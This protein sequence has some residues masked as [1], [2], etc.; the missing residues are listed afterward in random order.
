[1]FLLTPTKWYHTF[2]ELYFEVTATLKLDCEQYC[3]HCH[4]DV[5]E[6]T[7]KFKKHALQ[8]FLS[9]KVLSHGKTPQ[10]KAF[11][12]SL[13]ENRSNIFH[14]NH[15]PGENMGPIHCYNWLQRALFLRLE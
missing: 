1:M 14:A 12:R 15:I 3:S 2:I 13:K 6:F 11:V 9:T 7:G 5:C 4:R 10:Y 8:P